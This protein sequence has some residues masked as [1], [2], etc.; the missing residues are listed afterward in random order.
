MRRA[1]AFAVAMPAL[2][3]LAWLV[4]LGAW[5]S[6]LLLLAAAA[7]LL[8]R[9]TPR[10]A[11]AGALL[12][13]GAVAGGVPHREYARCVVALDARVERDGPEALRPPELLAVWGLNAALAAGGLGAGLPEAARETLHMALPGPHVRTF[14]SDFALRSPRVRG[15][16]LTMLQGLPAASPTTLDEHDPARVPLA[17][18]VVAWKG[19]F[20]ERDSPRVALALNPVRISGTAQRGK[21]GTRLS[22]V[23]RVDVVYPDHGVTQLPLLG[24][25]PYRL[26]WSLQQRGWLFP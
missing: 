24:P 19:Y 7:P 6:A 9:R 18:R 22:L 11:L 1:L 26:L 5:L 13:A 23:A 10:A 20:N 8:V 14:H 16:I 25:V 15:A 12:L 21:G 4:C 2:P 3:L 17:D